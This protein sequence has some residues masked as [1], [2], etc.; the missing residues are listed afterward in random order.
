[1]AP[2]PDRPDHR[3]GSPSDLR[4]GRGNEDPARIPRGSRALSRVDDVGPV[5][6]LVERARAGD[7]EAFGL[8]YDRY[9]APVFRYLAARVRDRAE[10]E[11]MAA[12][13]FVEV[14][15]R[16]GRFRGG[17][18][19]FVSWLFTIARNDVRDR[20]RRARRRVVE[21]VEEPPPAG[22]V[23]DPVDSVALR[24]EADRVRGALEALTDD[25][26]QVLLLKFA[27]GLSNAEVA[28]VL[29]KPVGA[30]KSLQHRALAAMRRL[31]GEAA[32][33]GAAR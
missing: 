20:L 16:I 22:E 13:V 3:R 25:Q 28:S 24:L 8:L 23:E 31:L 4:S 9:H 33:G 10:A 30:V 6:D 12:E 1:M 29:G 32:G 11:D 5:D 2:G 7:A 27:G 19:D 21:P 26:R 17:G 18:P 14:A 15:Q